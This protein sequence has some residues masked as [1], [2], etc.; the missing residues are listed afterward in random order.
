MWGT[1]QSQRERDLSLLS[2]SLSLS[3]LL[4]HHF[5]QTEQESS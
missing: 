4:I 3:D 5:K 1:H 2:L